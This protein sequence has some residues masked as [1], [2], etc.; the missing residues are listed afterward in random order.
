MP[1]LV[2]PSITVQRSFLAAMAEFL[3]EGRGSKSD[4]SMVAREL[5]EF[6]PVW[7]T[8]EG[9]AQYVERLRADAYESTL[10]ASYLVPST[11]Y[12][13]VDGAEYHGRIS[14]RHRLTPR[15]LEIGG[16][17]GYDV[18]PS[19]R[20]KGHATAMLR[21]VLPYAYDLGID[22]ALLTCDT[23]NVGSRKVIEAN[24]GVF[25]DERSGKLRFWVPTKVSSS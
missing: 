5:R 8:P 20:L 7:E 15:L 21:A 24:G 23:D 22:P 10:R 1:E 19:A 17:I 2:P 13:W 18:R 25:E 6:G 14:I 12:W 11:T 9:F 3:D 16:H 4:D